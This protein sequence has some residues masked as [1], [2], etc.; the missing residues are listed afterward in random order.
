VLATTGVIRALADQD[1][2]NQQV[3]QG[4]KVKY[5]SG[6]ITSVDPQNHRMEMKDYFVTKKFSLGDSCIYALVDGNTINGLR[7]GQKVKVT[8]WDNHG[9]LVANRII[10]EPLRHQ[11]VI[12]EINQADR[13]FE[14]RSHGFTRK[15]QIAEGCTVGLRNHKTGS[16]A[17]IKAGSYVNVTYEEPHGLTVARD[18]SQTSETFSGSLT[19]IDLTER[20]VKAKSM[21]DSKHF[22]VAKDCSIVINGK[23]GG[24]LSDLRPGE[25]LVFSYDDVDGVNVVNRIAN[26][27]ETQ[28]PNTQASSH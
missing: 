14:L 17:D 22:Q 10:Q 16:L 21:M 27:E 3:N 20:T 5:Y 28:E 15:M 19:A 23:M 6:T 4:E 24:S 26:S 12:T 8:C 1:T 11:G 18:I 25:K 2:A 7:A 9:V 13:T